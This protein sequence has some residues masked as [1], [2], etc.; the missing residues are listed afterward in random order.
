MNKLIKLYKDISFE[1]WDRLGFSE[2]VGS[3][4]SEPTIT[5]NLLYEIQKY[6][7]KH[8]DRSIHI[9]EAKNE[10]TNGNDLEVY[11]EIAKNEYLFLAIQAKKLHIKEQKYKYI[12]HKVSGNLQI[13]LLINYASKKHGV[14]LYLFYNYSPNL[15]VKN[16]KKYGCSFACAHHIKNNY[17]P[18]TSKKSWSIPT[19]NNLHTKHAIPFFL[20]GIKKIF[21]NFLDANECL[22][23][24]P[25]IK[26]YN[27]DESLNGDWIPIEDI[28]AQTQRFEL[29]KTIEHEKK[30]ELLMAKENELKIQKIDFVPKYK[31][32]IDLYTS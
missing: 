27:K 2:R 9:Y 28:K 32:V 21:L 29:C 11:M 25:K 14:P 1:T 23:S 30:L 24:S 19:F 15:A 26:T 6:K 7:D 4:L 10:K 31:M 16:N 20:L 5:E 13:D 18:N 17:S 8:H 12:S 3:T 22:A